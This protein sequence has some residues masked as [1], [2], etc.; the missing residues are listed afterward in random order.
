[1]ETFPSDSA[2]KNL[3]NEL[4]HGGELAKQLQLLLNA[5]SSSQETLVHLL[6][7]ILNTYDRALS[8]IEYG[9]T[10]VCA[11]GGAQPGRGGAMVATMS[12]SLCPPLTGIPHCNHSDPEDQACRIRY[13]KYFLVYFNPPQFTY[14]K[15]IRCV[16]LSKIASLPHRNQ[17][18]DL[19]TNN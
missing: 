19:K 10:S 11:G 7:E 12:D 17:I 14:T 5:Q 13:D 8:V 15:V 16:K 18:L 6:N 4:T 2:L 9:G 3:E 1:M